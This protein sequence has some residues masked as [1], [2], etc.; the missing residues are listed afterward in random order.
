M[1]NAIG[2]QN[3]GI[4]VFIERDIPFLKQYD[5]KIIVNVCGK[6]IKE[7]LEVVERL[8]DTDVTCWKSTYPAQM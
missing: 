4:D 8:A 3:P 2:L 6:T 1:L 5:T 7:Y